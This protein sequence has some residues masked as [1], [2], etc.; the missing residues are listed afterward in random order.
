MVIGLQIQ[1]KHFRTYGR[2]TIIS[3]TYIMKDKKQFESDHKTGKRYTN[4]IRL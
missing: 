3:L 1:G 4:A 2:L